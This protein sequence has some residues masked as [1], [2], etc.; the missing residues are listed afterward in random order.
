MLGVSGDLKHNEVVELPKKVFK[1]GSL[2]K[3]ISR[4]IAIGIIL[5]LIGGN[6]FGAILNAHAIYTSPVYTVFAG[7]PVISIVIL[8]L[9][10][11]KFSVVGDCVA[12]VES[13]HNVSAGVNTMPK[14]QPVSDLF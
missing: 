2:A 3:S 13:V 7:V 4:F 1:V 9:M 8:V 10:I 6:S 14:K 12:D 5:D 11:I